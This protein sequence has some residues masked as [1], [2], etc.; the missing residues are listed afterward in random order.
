MHA[1]QQRELQSHQPSRVQQLGTPGPPQQ[2]RGGSDEAFGVGEA[3]GGNGG[4]GVGAEEAQQPSRQTLQLQPQHSS[5][6]PGESF[7]AEAGGVD[8]QQRVQVYNVCK[9]ITKLP[10]Y[11]QFTSFFAFGF[12]FSSFSPFLSRYVSLLRVASPV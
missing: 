6:S 2:M 7:L 9:S 11:K 10:C 4:A 1:Q 8:T 3:F 12:F 5:S